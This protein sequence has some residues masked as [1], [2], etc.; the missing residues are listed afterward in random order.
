MM[1]N[2]IV[3]LIVYLFFGFS[4]KTEPQL[5]LKIVKIKWI[6][7]GRYDINLE[8]YNN[9]SQKI[10]YLSMYCSNSGL[11]STNNQYVHVVPKP[12][13]INFPTK[14]TILRNKY[15]TGNLQLELAKN[16]KQVEFK[17]GFQFIEIPESV[18]INEF[19]STSV[20]SII[21]WSN[22]IEFKT[23]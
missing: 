15:R 1:K 14:V 6:G 10:S 12:C 8:L 19:D 5:T 22:T 21:V 17:V 11:Y 23:R 4:T 7:D 3:L 9:S 20:K 16:A 2:A 13:N 18:Q